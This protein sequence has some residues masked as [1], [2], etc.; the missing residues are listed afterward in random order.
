MTQLAPP[1]PGSPRTSTTADHAAQRMTS[2]KAPLVQDCRI[3]Q[4][5]AG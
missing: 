2:P 5:V 1:L 3:T 4:A